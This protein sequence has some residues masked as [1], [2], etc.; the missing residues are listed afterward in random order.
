MTA[1]NL[2]G[3]APRVA[4]TG[5]RGFIGRALLRQPGVVSIGLWQ[6]TGSTDYQTSLNGVDAVIHAAARVHVMCETHTDPLAAFRAANVDVT[7]NLARQAAE[8]GVKRFIFL[9]TVKVNGEASL[10][11]KPFTAAD[12]PAPED[13][14]AISKYEAEQG[15]IQLARDT[16]MEV[17]IVRPPLVYGPGVKG[18]FQQLIKW[19]RRGI[20]LPLKSIENRRSLIALDNLVDLLMVC[21]SHPKAGNK[22]FLASDGEDLSTQELLRRRR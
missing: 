2:S 19:L 11:G 17:V 1:G 15:L 9:S 10:I 14:Y 22:I 16:A 13:P 4:I 18:N 8:A 7:V 6:L 21:A 12:L 5:E 20:P 3:T